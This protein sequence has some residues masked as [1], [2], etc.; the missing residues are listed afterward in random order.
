MLV[1]KPYHHPYIPQ[2][3]SALPY[4]GKE[5]EELT[6]ST[7]FW[8]GQG[9]PVYQWDQSPSTRVQRNA[10]YSG[11]PYN[12]MLDRLKALRAKA[13]GTA[14]TVANVASQTA[15]KA[16]TAQSLLTTPAPS[17]FPTPTRSVM[18]QFTRPGQFAPQGQ[19]KEE[20]TGMSPFAKVGIGLGVVVVLSVVTARLLAD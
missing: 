14:E 4:V 17:A 20:K 5:L 3:P 19:P 18:P 15:D 2:G 13:K 9:I 12:G 10:N 8:R 7:P 1:Q 11:V 16:T 6:S